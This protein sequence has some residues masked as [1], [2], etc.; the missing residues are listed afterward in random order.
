MS[1]INKALEPFGY[2]VE[3]VKRNSTGI[4]SFDYAF[5]FKKSGQKDLLVSF[6]GV[7]VNLINA[8]IE[9]PQ[10]NIFKWSNY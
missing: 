9:N 4:V 8:I 5:I 7:A 2:T 10:L 3:R 6:R 1:T